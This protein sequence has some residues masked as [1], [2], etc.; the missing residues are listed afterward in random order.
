VAILVPNGSG[1]STL[2]NIL[3]GLIAPDSGRFSI[4]NFDPFTFSYL[5]QNY[6]SSL[7]PW[8][9]CLGNIALPLEIQGLKHFSTNKKVLRCIR[10][11]NFRLNLKT[12][13]Y[14]LSG[15]EQQTLAFI[16][17]LVTEPTLLFLDVPFSALD[18]EMNLRLRLTFANYLKS[19]RPTALFVSHN[20]E[21]AVHLADKILVL[22]KGPTKVSAKIEC[23][24]D[25]RTNP[26]VINSAEFLRVKKQTLD[27]F[28]SVAKL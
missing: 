27:A 17:A 11:Y 19:R 6:R 14:Q 5:F 23:N 7:L 10:K 9:N 22:S 25:D 26:S 12:Y 18:Y 13:P 4:S 28:L 8:R 15:G 20:I 24:L 2:L 21:E 16:R 3:S 1:K